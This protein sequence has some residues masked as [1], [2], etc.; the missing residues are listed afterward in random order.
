[1][2]IAAFL[3]ADSKIYLITISDMIFINFTIFFYI[4]LTG[5]S[6]KPDIRIITYPYTVM[7]SMP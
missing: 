7:R 4:E 1:M 5:I 6:I 3:N 2:Y